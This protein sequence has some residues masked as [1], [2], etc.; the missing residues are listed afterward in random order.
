MSQ[1]PSPAHVSITSPEGESKLVLNWENPAVEDG[2]YEFRFVNKSSFT[3][4][5]ILF[6]K[7]VVKSSGEAHTAELNF[8]KG[9]FELAQKCHA[10]I[11]IVQGKQTSLWIRKTAITAG[12]SLSVKVG[13]REL[14]FSSNGVSQTYAGVLDLRENPVDMNVIANR[15]LANFGLELPKEFPV[16]KFFFLSGYFDST[17]EIYHLEAQTEV[18]FENPFG[19]KSAK[20][21]FR[22]MELMLDILPKKKLFSIKGEV[23]YESSGDIHFGDAVLVF[24]TGIHVFGLEIRQSIS[25]ADL[26][27]SFLKIDHIH[28]D[29]RDLLPTFGPLS[30]T[31]PILLYDASATY[32]FRGYTYQSG[33][34]L[35]QL[36][37][38]LF[39]TNFLVS[40]RIE[41]GFSLK[42]STDHI[43]LVEDFLILK[44]PKSKPSEGI[45]LK[46]ESHGE[47]KSVALSGGMLFFPEGDK[48]AIDFK[49][50]Y[51]AGLFTGS[52]EYNPYK[53]S[54]SWDKK[55]GFHITEFNPLP[56]ES[57]MKLLNWAEKLQDFA[58]QNDS[59]TKACEKITD[60]AFKEFIQTKF[61]FKYAISKSDKVPEPNEDKYVGLDITGSYTVT[62]AGYDIVIP[63]KT[64]LRAEVKIPKGFSDLGD[65]ILKTLEKNIT[66]IALALWDNKEQLP[67]FLGMLTFVE[68]MKSAKAAAC[69]IG[70]KAGEEALKEAL[71]KFVDAAVKAAADLALTTLE[72]AAAVIVAVGG[73]LKALKALW[74][75]ITGGPSEEDKR[76]EREAKAKKEEAERKIKS[77]LKIENLNVE[78]DKNASGSAK[79]I[80]AKWSKITTDAGGGRIYYVISLKEKDGGTV[81]SQELNIDQTEFK[82]SKSHFDN[83]KNYIVNVQAYY[84]K[85]D[86]YSGSS[87]EKP[88]TT[89]ILQN[90]DPVTIDPSED[91]KRAGII[92]VSWKD[93][94]IMPAGMANAKKTGY[95]VSLWKLSPDVLIESKILTDTSYAFQLYREDAEKP[96]VPDPKQQ[97]EI[98]LHGIASDSDLNSHTVKT[99]VFKIPWGIGFMRVGYNFEIKQK[100]D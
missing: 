23:H 54:F 27:E 73:I 46:V 99:N 36:V 10:E 5:K 14:V 60:L 51:S 9:N 2:T 38:T 94:E 6:T 72:E 58:N 87:D 13:S 11:R 42:A 97:Y 19:V 57:V 83:G 62:V 4:V 17:A 22:K 76:K 30:D 74:D 88:V 35:D 31:Q 50:A 68:G 63:M 37:I 59:C 67:K 66:N 26:L 82:I 56:L 89:P 33:F 78:Y 16:L 44:G 1:L 28:E 29:I 98:R 8:D 79:N 84:Q 80:H 48:I 34:N 52:I 95:E 49:V 15:F 43:N 21:A 81:F 32:E 55:G 100:T 39:K 93:V 92:D 86:T 24:G 96:F 64:P 61:D 18:E 77:L 69:R 41:N 71:K 45:M 65:S 85:G 75:W 7:S 91:K 20:I 25:M 70:C 40:L 53:L 12:A 47:S 3:P 90:P